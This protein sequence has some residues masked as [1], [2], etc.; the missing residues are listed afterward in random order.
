MASASDEP[1]VREDVERKTE[2][3]AFVAPKPVL[4]PPASPACTTPSPIAT[5]VA[6]GL[7]VIAPPPAATLGVMLPKP[8]E[9]CN[10]ELGPPNS[11]VCA[12][13]IETCATASS[14]T[15]LV[16]AERLRGVRI[17]AAEA[18]TGVS[19]YEDM[20]TSVAS[21][22]LSSVAAAVPLLALRT[23][24]SSRSPTCGGGSMS[25]ALFRIV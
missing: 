22:P 4:A 15:V 20:S 12:S 14:S 21:E 19:L 18:E 7:G 8:D 6:S 17:I 16:E 23:R 25:F 2:K 5:G 24:S 1:P 13:S 10:V 3:R 9:R 11:G